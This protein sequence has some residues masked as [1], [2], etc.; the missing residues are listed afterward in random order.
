MM[1]IL[2]G[3][4]IGIKNG[5][6]CLPFGLKLAYLNYDITVATRGSSWS[7]ISYHSMKNETKFDSF[8]NEVIRGCV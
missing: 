5:R 7:L 3:Q 4:W 2:Q 6:F 1:N 8:Y